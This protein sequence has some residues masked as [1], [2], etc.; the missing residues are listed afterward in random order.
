MSGLVKLFK[1]K[2][3]NYPKE[4]TGSFAGRTILIT[5][6]NQG[7]GFEAAVKFAALGASKLI[8]GVRS[9]EKGIKAKASIERRTGRRDLVQVWPLDMLDYNSVRAFASRANNDLEHLDIAIL[10]AGALFPKFETTPYGWER[11]LQVNTLSTILLA[12]LLLPKLRAS[13]TST[14]T[15]TL[16]LVSS[17]SHRMVKWSDADL[18]APNPLEHFNDPANFSGQKQYGTSKLLLMCALPHLVKLATDPSSNKPT[19]YVTTVCPGATQS[20]LG[21]GYMTW[22]LKPIAI[23]FF[24]LF[25]RSTATGART[26]VSG[27]QLDE[28][29]VGGFWQHDE[30]QPYVTTSS[31]LSG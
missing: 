21:R 19:T 7:V 11:T 15:P 27:A 25:F 1:Q 4:P 16:E 13:Q 17:G 18:E 5:G 26:Y 29:G 22:Y 20:S 12:L 3:F 14:Y 6:A 2:W 8:I 28:R 9:I 31:Q 30:L 10:N 24:T 23:L